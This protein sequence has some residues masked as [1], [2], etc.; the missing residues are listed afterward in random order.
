MNVLSAFL[1]HRSDVKDLVREVALHLGRRGIRPWLDEQELPPG[2][3]L[4]AR[5]RAAVTGQNLCVVFLSDTAIG[6]S[7]V[8]EELDVAI[9]LEQEGREESI[10]P[11]F[12]AGHAELVRR[13]P[14]MCRLWMDATDSRVERLGIDGTGR[15]AAA[16][17]AAIA[18]RAYEQAST[19]ERPELAILV[20]QRGS[21]PRRGLPALPAAI[22]AMDGPALLFRPDMAERSLDATV[23]HE[24]WDTVAATMREALVR[25]VDLSPVLSPVRKQRIHWFGTCQMALAALFGSVVERS[26][27]KELVLHDLHGRSALVDLSRFHEPLRGG[28][29]SALLASFT[30]RDAAVVL[31]KRDDP[32]LALT[33]DDAA[34]R[35]LP[36]VDVLIPDLVA[37]GDEMLDVARSL[38]ATIFALRAQGMQRLFLYNLGP[39]HILAAVVSLLMHVIEDLLVVEWV[40]SEQRYRPYA[41]RPSRP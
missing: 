21:G 2:V 22:E 24:D 37:T 23:S 10:V 29:V 25:A 9:D 35:R 31:T 17:A 3:D 6:S 27:G 4:R 12:L 7:W 5:L 30:G 39:A 18:D 8:R 41:L 16:I 11:V 38:T 20:D 34:A 26:S 1:S 33:R 15:D 14:R 36:L 32:R 40:K 13:H 28:A 19:R